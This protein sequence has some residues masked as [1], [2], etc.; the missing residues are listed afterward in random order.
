MNPANCLSSRSKVDCTV[1]CTG[2]AGC[3]G[4]LLRKNGN[5]GTYFCDNVSI[6]YFANALLFII[7]RLVIIC[8]N[9]GY[10]CNAL[11]VEVFRLFSAHMPM[12]WLI[13]LHGSIQQITAAHT[14]I[15]NSCRDIAEGSVEAKKHMY[16][17]TGKQ[18]DRSVTSSIW[19]TCDVCNC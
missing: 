6:L 4:T 11:Q 19:S 1:T 16:A 7:G 15:L 8:K 14:I 2:V 5:T 10:A 12:L 13:D 3:S 18:T 9:G 17:V